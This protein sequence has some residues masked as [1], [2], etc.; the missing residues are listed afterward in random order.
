MYVR[1]LFNKVLILVFIVIAQNKITSSWV[2]NDSDED[3]TE[4]DEDESDEDGDI[5]T[6]HL[7]ESENSKFWSTDGIVQS[8]VRQKYSYVKDNYA[9]LMK[10]GTCWILPPEPLAIITDLVPDSFMFPEIFIWLPEELDKNTKLCCPHCSS[11]DTIAKEWPTQPARRILSLTGSFFLICRRMFCKNCKKK[12]MN[13]DPRVVA[14]LPAHLQYLFPALLTKKSAVDIELATLERALI[15]EGLGTHAL[16][17]VI[18]EMQK[19]QYDRKQIRY[20]SLALS[21]KNWE[22]WP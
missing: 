9:K 6:E 3:N 14:K 7:S 10:E 18:Q 12:F 20:Y 4:D 19:I 15:N 8:Y 11:A 13:S 2:Q 22:A 5:E 21:K 1:L 17:R 16:Q